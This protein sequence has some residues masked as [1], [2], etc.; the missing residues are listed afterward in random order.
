VRRPDGD[1]SAAHS[2]RLLDTDATA[3]ERRVLAAAQRQEPSAAS[4]AR[5][6]AALGVSVTAAGI[7]GLGTAAA[8]K[9]AVAG[10]AASKA[11]AAA[12]LSAVW[13]WISAGVVGLAV[14]GAVVGTRARHDAHEPP[15]VA[16]PSVA[17]APSPPPA[18]APSPER[19]ALPVE[20]R[21]AVPEPTPAPRAGASSARARTAAPA[22]SDL[23][24]QIAVLDSARA[25]I[26]TGAGRRALEI[27]RRYQ[28]R[29][30]TGSLRPEAVALEVEALMKSGREAEARALARRFVAEHRG[31]LLARQV[32]D[33][34]GLP[35]P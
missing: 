11:T 28:D 32:A 15:P 30:P 29:Y 26:A 13:T 4:T 22:T 25:A 5:M 27:L 8:A 17:P 9:A 35:K 18:A 7:A 1:P 34:A 21:A 16:S 14:A 31:S 10:A 19:L 3:F 20:P 23:G 33:V 24:D 6:A 2:G 12:G